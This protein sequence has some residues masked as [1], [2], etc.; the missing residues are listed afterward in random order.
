MQIDTPRLSLREL[1]EDDAPHTQIYE[2]EPA[3]VRYQSFAPRSLLESLEY[4]QASMATAREVPRSI[5]DLTVVL[6]AEQVLVGRCGLKV[7]E[8]VNREGAL[9]FIL[10][11][12]YWGRGIIPQAARAPL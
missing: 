11:P 8:P 12:A 4:I 7:A 5:F 1:R 10:N 9:W 2:C 3:V 6:R